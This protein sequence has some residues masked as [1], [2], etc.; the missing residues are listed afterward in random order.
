MNINFKQPRYVL[1]LI[2][3]PFLCLFFFIYHSGFAA[4][5]PETKQNAGINN[6]VG[7]VSSDVQKQQ[8]EDKLARTLRNMKSQNKIEDSLYHQIFPTGTTLGPYMEHPKLTNLVALLGRI[9]PRDYASVVYTPIYAMDL[10]GPSTFLLKI[11]AWPLC[12]YVLS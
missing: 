3:L 4:K 7:T 10:F 9:I 8:L 1:P 5:K 11:L 2:L 6:K 12:N